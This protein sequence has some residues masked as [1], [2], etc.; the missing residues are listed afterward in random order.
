MRMHNAP[1][2]DA[3]QQGR[4]HLQATVT[5]YQLAVVRRQPHVS[6]MDAVLEPHR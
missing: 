2:S 3:A 5:R 6:R 1:A 4:L